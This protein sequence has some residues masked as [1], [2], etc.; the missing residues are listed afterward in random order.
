MI[1]LLDRFR[2]CRVGTYELETVG[3]IA[4][5]DGKEGR[6]SGG[7]GTGGTGGRDGSFPGLICFLRELIYNF[8]WSKR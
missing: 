7:G 5:T 2:P 6:G 8:S 1:S 4:A 3:G